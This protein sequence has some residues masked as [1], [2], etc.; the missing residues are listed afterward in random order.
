LSRRDPTSRLRTA[1]TSRH[2][3]RPRAA[4]ARSDGLS[5]HRDSVPERLESR[6]SNSLSQRFSSS[7]RGK[8][9]TRSQAASPIIRRG[10]AALRACRYRTPPAAADEL[11]RCVTELGFKGGNIHR[12]IGNT[13][14]DDSRHLPILERAAALRVPINLHPTLPHANILEPYLCYGKRSADY[15]RSTLTRTPSREKPSSAASLDAR[16]FPSMLAM[17]ALSRRNSRAWPSLTARRSGR[18]SGR[19]TLGRRVQALARED[20]AV[21][22]Y[23]ASCVGRPPITTWWVAGPSSARLLGYA[24]GSSEHRGQFGGSHMTSPP[25]DLAPSCRSRGNVAL[26]QP[27]PVLSASSANRLAHGARDRD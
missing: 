23:L 17:R 13:Y 24:P 27:P 18:T 11:E 22:G 10:S 2:A 20:R 9:T 5:R 26:S 25:K 6:G 21:A 14:L 19:K 7:T 15:A 4:A 12:Y 16:S 3:A 1:I 8:P